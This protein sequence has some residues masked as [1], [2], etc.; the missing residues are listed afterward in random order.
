MTTIPMQLLKIGRLYI[1]YERY[2]FTDISVHLGNFVIEYQG[3]NAIGNGAVQDYNRSPDGKTS[4]S[5][6]AIQ[7][8]RSGNTRSSN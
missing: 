2:K 5:N 6:G 1:G 7:K 4:E 8:P 3:T